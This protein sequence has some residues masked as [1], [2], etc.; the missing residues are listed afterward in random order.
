MTTVADAIG[1]AVAR[2]GAPVAFGLA[3]SGNLRLINGLSAAGV[4]YRASCH[5]AGAVGMADGY[6][7]VSGR[8]GVATVHQ[9]PGLTNTTTAMI[10]AV[11]A[12]TPLVLLTAE[13]GRANQGLH[14][15]AL[16][17]VAGA[18]VE[19]IERADDVDRAFRRARAERR[20]IVGVVPV[21]IQARSAAADAAGGTEPASPPP[22][23]PDERA[24]A[25]LA[26]LVEGA[27][28][29]AILAGRGAALS[30]ARNPLAELG[31]RTGALLATTAPAK[32]FFAGEPFDVGVMGG[33][34]SPLAADLIQ[35]SDLLL[36]F[37]TSLDPWTTCDGR[38]PG[39]GA[40]IAQIDDDPRALA[41]G[42]VAAVGDAAAAAWALLAELERRDI[43]SLAGWRSTE[44]E[45]AI[46]AARCGPEPGAAGDGLDPRRL[47][48]AL[49]RALPPNR[50]VTVD[51]G[52]F[53]V[54]P[55]VYVDSPDELGF[56]FPQAF[57]AVGLALA[58]A[59]GAAVARPDRIGAAMIGDG[60]AMM[61]LLELDTA[62]RYRLPLLVVIFNDAAYGAE[63]HDF[64]SHGV[65][66][67]A[68][69]FPD[70]DFAAMA[71]AL[72]AHATTVRAIEDLGHI[73]RWLADPAGPLVLDCKVDPSID[74]VS[75]M[76]EVGARHWSHPH[77]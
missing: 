76:S 31:R 13:G 28:A 6:A 43:A 33:L 14:Q 29:P 59:I 27:R 30:G 41:A 1:Q 10:E 18:G 71:L 7:R 55:A 56:V 57:Q 35:R 11:K 19:R 50:T 66:V 23:A 40:R 52:H 70:R 38:L 49:D 48:I 32:G 2:Q 20:P 44:L 51:S 64:E 46:R 12:S 68:A 24:V 61:S 45:R 62:V 8:I 16:A 69:R 21:E 60:G 3:G 72:G 15:A 17:A 73:E 34:S 53:L 75:A 63:V 22:T 36:A 58:V 65:P 47:A 4:A 37:G 54:F 26:D 77:P 5:E 74:A 42:S 25:R 67:D 39:P 9:G